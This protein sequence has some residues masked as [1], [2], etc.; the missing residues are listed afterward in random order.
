M[1][2]TVAALL[3][4][5]ASPAQPLLPS[6]LALP[7]AD[8]PRPKATA[9][10]GT[11]PSTP[12]SGETHLNLSGVSLGGNSQGSSSPQLTAISL[13]ESRN[14]DSLSGIRVPDPALEK[15]A[16]VTPAETRPSTRSWLLLSFVQHGTAAFDAYSTRQAIGRG[17]VEMDPLMRPF[18]H[19]AGIYPAIQVGPVLLDILARHM[20]RSENRFARRMW[21]APQSVSTAGF[22]FSGVHNLGV[23]GHR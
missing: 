22:L 16:K 2:L 6:A 20:Q 4:Q 7:A 13:A 18:A 5:L 9:T 19:S 8:T 11:E 14:S 10:A 17:A 12:A 1:V 21:W 23:S 3:F 15:P